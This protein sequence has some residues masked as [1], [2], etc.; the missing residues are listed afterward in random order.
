MWQLNLFFN[1]AKSSVRHFNLRRQSLQIA[2]S[3]TIINEVENFRK[4]YSRELLSK[5]WTSGLVT[6]QNGRYLKIVKWL[7]LWR[8][9]HEKFSSSQGIS[10]E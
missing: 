9:Y 10:K 1:P 4:N 5:Y 7:Q 6:Q 8:Q 3:G 2:H